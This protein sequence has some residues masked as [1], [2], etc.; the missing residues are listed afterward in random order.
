MAYQGDSKIVFVG[1]IPFDRTEDELA[2]LFSQAG[3]LVSFRLLIDKDALKPRGYGFAEYHDHETA[4]CAVRNLNEHDLGGRKLR[5]NFADDPN[6]QS[7]SAGGN[8]VGGSSNANRDNNSPM[9]PRSGTPQPLKREPEPAPAPAPSVPS[10]AGTPLQP[11]MTAT[12]A[13]SKVIDAMPKEQKLDILS[14]LKTL[15]L[16]YP[17]QARELLNANPQLAYS[18]MMIMMTCGLVD[19]PAIQR[20]VTAVTPAAPPVPAAAAVPM[21]PAAPYGFPP[22]A[23]MVPGVMPMAPGM[24]PGM[25]M[26]GGFM[27]AAAAAI[28]EQ[29]RQLLAQ[30]M[31]LTPAQIE[32]MPPE[33]KATV[34]QVRAQFMQF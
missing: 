1:N 10:V 26:T 8:Y 11:G 15:S 28:S 12:D 19:A 7:V 20:I 13:I 29:Q 2:E 32:M 34:L 3:P 30:V 33:Q 4:R 16:T 27:P 18:I 23:G 31:S 17:D 9:P 22:G 24:P 14:H 21:V 5:V 6:T 25:P